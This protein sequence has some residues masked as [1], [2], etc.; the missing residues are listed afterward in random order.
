MKMG[1]LSL[2]ILLALFFSSCQ[3]PPLTQTA[4]PSK[5][6][7]TTAPLPA[8]ESP[9]P[10]TLPPTATPT[11]IPVSARS[12]AGLVISSPILGSPHEVPGVSPKETITPN[13]LGIINSEGRLIPFTDAGLFESFSPSGQQ[14]VYQHGFE[15][16][17]TDYIDNLYLYNIMTDETVEI[18]DDLKEEG[19]KNVLAWSPDEK[20]FFYENNYLSV[21]F[22]AYGYF[23]PRQLLMA[24]VPSGRTKVLI[25]DGYQFDVSPDQKQIAYTTGELLKSKTIKYGDVAREFFGCFQP[26][27]YDVHSSTSRPFDMSQLEEQPVCAGYPAWSPDG[28]KIAW[29]GYF[30]DDTFRPI[31]FNLEQNTGKIYE[32]LD[33][34]PISSQSPIDWRLGEQFQ[35][36]DWADPATLWT[37]S[38]EINVETGE[39]S[40][41][42][43]L[44]VPYYFRRDKYLKAPDGSIRVSMNDELDAILVSDRNGNVLASFSLDELYDGPRQE[45]LTDPFFL[46]GTNHIVDWAPVIPPVLSGGN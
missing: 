16:E 40:A 1:T 12:L 29:M 19:G 24:D 18:V 43:E 9:T 41:P 6:I 28:K 13:G 11:L 22:E 20:K 33:Q 36:P 39:T 5:M 25:K 3:S 21:L 44:V 4:A 7:P 2:L 10:T 31:I 30:E 42:R 8:T 14:I 34:K 32:P 38:Y 23:R 27:I 15:D 17:Y 26:R 35:D 45:I 37:P 46:S